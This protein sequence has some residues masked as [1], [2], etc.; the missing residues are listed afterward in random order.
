MLS[1]DDVLPEDLLVALVDLGVRLTEAAAAIVILLGA[2]VAVV[3]FVRA[4]VRRDHDDFT[5]V[6]LR[7]GR[8]LALG[9]ELQLASDV[10]RTTIAPSFEELG[11]LAVVAAI[12]TALNFFLAREIKEESA[13]VGHRE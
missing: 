3:G 2:A 12:R 1:L 4:L 10:L 8:Y 5:P 9:L 6:R 11:K 13:Q 7:L